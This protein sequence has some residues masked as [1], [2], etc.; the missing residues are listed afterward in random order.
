MGLLP[1]IQRA[2]RRSTVPPLS[3]SVL[4]LPPNVCLS[5]C[6]SVYLSVSVGML[7][8]LCLCPCL[9]V[10]FSRL[11]SFFAPTPPSVASPSL[12]PPSR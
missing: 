1:P 8:C 11:S 2:K 5:V 12:H 7:V 6:L 4:P 9:C 3:L 10:C